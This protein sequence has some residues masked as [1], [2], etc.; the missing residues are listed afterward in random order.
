MNL[1]IYLGK[2]LGTRGYQ[3]EMRVRVATGLFPPPRVQLGVDGL[4]IE[5]KD[6]TLLGHR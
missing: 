1:P 4:G 6:L 2:G 3:S 5:P